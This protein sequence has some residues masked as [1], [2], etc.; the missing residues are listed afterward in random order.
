MN[1]TDAVK[2][3][4]DAARIKTLLTLNAKGNELYADIWTFGIQVALRISDLL[5]ITFEDCK[6]ER[7][8]IKESKTGKTRSISLTATASA[9]IAKRKS[10][11]PTHTF[12]F[13]VDSNRAKGK[14]V[15]RVSVARAF[16]AVGQEIGVNL[17][18]HSMRKTLGWAMYSGGRKVEEVCKVLGHANPATTMLYLGI[19]QSEIDASY[20][21]FEIAI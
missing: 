7:L 8:I 5:S 11:N 12:L 19:T 2:T 9:I 10:A 17:G 13:E 21:E 1:M 14:P 4:E 6:G 15:S 18:T 3:K 20:H 16:Q